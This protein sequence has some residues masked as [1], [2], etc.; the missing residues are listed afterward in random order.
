MAQRNGSRRVRVVHIITNLATGGAEAMLYKLLSEMNTDEFDQ[1][2]IVLMSEA[3]YGPRIRALGIPVQELGMPQGK[4]NI[5]SLRRLRKLVREFN[6]DILQG[7]MYHGNLAALAGKYLGKGRPNVCWNIRQTL[8]SLDKEKKLTRLVIRLGGKLS[9]APDRIIYN[10]AVSA[11]QHEAESYNAGKRVVIPN[12]FDTEAFRFDPTER[13]RIRDELE[14]RDDMVLIAMVARYHPMKD[15]QNL[16][17]AAQL[18]A[19]DKQD[20][21]YVLVGHGSD[22]KQPALTNEI[23]RLG[24]GSQFHLLGERHDIMSILSASDLL[25]LPS[26]WGEGFPNAVG[27]AMACGLPCVVTDIGDSAAIVAECGVVVP[28]GDSTALAEAIMELVN[29][30]KSERREIG[31]RA[32][33]RVENNY[34]LGEIAREYEQLYRDVL[35][36]T[37]SVGDGK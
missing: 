24:L 27:E 20:V 1:S 11:N 37:V 9:N 17:R 36:E 31:M 28:P 22:A 8:Y 29:H 30:S 32:R 33:E 6:P 13:R 25:V 7:W 12:G 26:A 14:I 5:G 35:Q 4:P 2:V 3:V 19:R 10:S 18:V 15:H 16:I 21:R 34:S 23:Q